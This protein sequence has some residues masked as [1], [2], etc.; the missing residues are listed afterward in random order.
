MGS[1]PA[2]DTGVAVEID[3]PSEGMET[4]Q[5]VPT[6]GVQPLGEPF[7]LSLWSMS[8]LSPLS[9]MTSGPAGLRRFERPF[10]CVRRRRPEY[11]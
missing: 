7:A 9:S 5:V 3:A 8:P 11:E 6:D 1:R 10:G 2:G 4:G